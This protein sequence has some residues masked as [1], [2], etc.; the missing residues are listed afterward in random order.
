MHTA[1]LSRRSSLVAV[2]ATMA[3]VFAGSTVPTP[4]YPMYRQHLGFSRVTL[5]LVF[6]VY[7]VGTM[8][9]LFFAGRLSDQI[10]RRRTIF[11]AM[12]CLVASTLVFVFGADEVG[13]FV[14]RVLTGL[15]VGLGAGTCTAWIADLDAGGE[16][17][18]A[19]LAAAANMAGLGLGAV[20]AGVLARWAAEPLVLSWVV[21]LDIAFALLVLLWFVA[22][23]VSE[24]VDRLRELSLRPRL[25]VPGDR[26]ARFVAPA[27][28]AF[29]IFAMG[30]FYAA[31]IPSVLGQALHRTNPA[32][33]G[34]LV[35]EFFL[36]GAVIMVVTPWLP[37]RRAMLTGL[38]LIVPAGWLLVLATVAHSLPLLLVATAVGAAGQ[39][40][41]YRGGL[42]VVNRLAPQENRAEVLSTYLLCCYLGL[43]VAP[44]GVAVLTSVW[45]LVPAESV[46]AGLLLVISAV[47]LAVELRHGSSTEGDTARSEHVADRRLEPVGVQRS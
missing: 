10:G 36:G 8:A 41:G 11:L 44:V 9:A 30:G 43:A 23:T 26:R 25:G 31:L 16:T 37:D 2:L 33:S 27:T 42:S 5:S 29:C 1:R 7:V 19:M 40:L 22:D 38:V 34:G 32:L 28:N 46:F 20:G 14:G 3:L 45:G 17:R 47:G 13:L 12:G 4:L 39:A 35:A 6:A 18:S 24:P 21:Y 15:A